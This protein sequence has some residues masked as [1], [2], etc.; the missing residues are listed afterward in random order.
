MNFNFKKKYGQNFLKNDSVP[1]KI[2]SNINTTDD[3]L[4]LEIGP[5]SGALTKHLSKMS[6]NVIC[7]EIDNELASYL[8]KYESDKLKIIYDDFMNRNI[9]QDI[10]TYNYDKLI[11]IGNLPYYITTPIILKVIESIIPDEMIIMVQKEVA[12]RFSSKP[13][14]REYGSITVLL[15]Y[16]FNIETLFVVKRNEFIPAPNVDSAVVKF[17]KKDNVNVDMVKFNKFLRDVFQFKRKN[18][19]NN[20]KSYDLDKIECILNKYNFSL[21]NRAEDL[22]IEV[23][24]D[25]VNNI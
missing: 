1:S 22:P 21:N 12:D 18:L 15:N 6:L 2:V 13:G 24:I 20:L 9:I 3:S 23:F 5:G 11:I 8:N 4:V 10:S 16:Y 25:I 19:R 17:T 14:S 7:Y